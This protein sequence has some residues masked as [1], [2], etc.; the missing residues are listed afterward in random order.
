MSS[1]SQQ[2]TKV[3][4]I[5]MM[6]DELLEI[7]TCDNSRDQYSVVKDIESRD[8]VLGTRGS[9]C[10]AIVLQGSYIMVRDAIGFGN[11]KK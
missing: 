11:M 10:E 2:Q 5:K 8:R 4:D 9:A 1:P 6:E 3:R 7:C